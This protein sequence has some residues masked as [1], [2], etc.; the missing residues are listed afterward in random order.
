MHATS[1]FEALRA[2]PSLL[3]DPSTPPSH[4][5][6]DGHIDC[7]AGLKVPFAPPSLYSCFLLDFVHV[8]LRVFWD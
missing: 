1:T 2:Q 3:L 5:G 7:D 8:L 4:I 6:S